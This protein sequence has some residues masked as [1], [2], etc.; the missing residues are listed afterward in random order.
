MKWAG[1]FWDDFIKRYKKP[2]DSMKLDLR[3]LD[4]R[5]VKFPP[6]QPAVEWA[7]IKKMQKRI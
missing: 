7:R 2:Y 5:S 3:K 4:H 6:V 1:P